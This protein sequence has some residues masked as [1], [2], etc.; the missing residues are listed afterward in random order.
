MEVMQAQ[1]AEI[2]IDMTVEQLDVGSATSTFFEDLGHDLYCAGWSGRT[3]P[4]QTTN[5]VLAADSFYNPGPYDS[6][7]IADAAPPA[8]HRAGVRQHRRVHPEPLRQVDVSFRC[9]EF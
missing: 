6:P 7:G 2:G 1:L 9:R 4:S 3:D 8:R 5:S